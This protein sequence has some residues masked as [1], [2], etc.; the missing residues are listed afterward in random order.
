M[1]HTAHK[2][3]TVTD[4]NGESPTSLHPTD[5]GALNLLLFHKTI[6]ILLLDKGP[7]QTCITMMRN[8]EKLVGT[9]L[10][11]RL[12]RHTLDKASRGA[13]ET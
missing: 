3:R 5:I 4:I 2:S 7:A 11:L 8:I 6:T 13:R 9:L 12:E 10:L 1:V